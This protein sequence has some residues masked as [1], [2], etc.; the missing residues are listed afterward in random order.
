[1]NKKNIYFSGELCF[2]IGL[3]DADESWF[4]G[5][6]LFFFVWYQ[7]YSK[8]ISTMFRVIFLNHVCFILERIQNALLES[9]AEDETFI[10][11]T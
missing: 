6:S 2:E 3:T 7:T 8:L 1:M 10:D 5:K 11:L 9:A 4:S